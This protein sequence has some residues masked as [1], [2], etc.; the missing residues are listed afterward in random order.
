MGVHG[1]ER[2]GRCLKLCE[3]GSSSEI[4]EMWV[5]LRD[6]RYMGHGSRIFWDLV[7]ALNR[8]TLHRGC[9]ACVILHIEEDSNAKKT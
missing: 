1:N 8:T 4:L 7:L 3:C 5:I 6:P 2:E 9:H